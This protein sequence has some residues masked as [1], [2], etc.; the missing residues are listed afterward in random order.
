MANPNE[1]VSKYWRNDKRNISIIVSFPFSG[2]IDV[3]RFFVCSHIVVVCRSDNERQA[4]HGTKC[5]FY[6][7]RYLRNIN[8]VIIINTIGEKDGRR[9]KSF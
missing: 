4:N 2:T 9:N 3:Y 1:M 6:R 5:V 7:N 8:Q